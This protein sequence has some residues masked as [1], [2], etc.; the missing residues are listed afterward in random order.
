[1]VS[2]TKSLKDEGYHGLLPKS[3]RIRRDIWKHSSVDR[4]L[5]HNKRFERGAVVLIDN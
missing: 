3:S 5:E 1:M 2:V 4:R